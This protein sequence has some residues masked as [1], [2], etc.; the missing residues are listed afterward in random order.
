VSARKV[1]IIGHSLPPSDAYLR[2]FLRS[3]L[4]KNEG[5]TVLVVDPG[6]GLKSYKEFLDGFLSDRVTYE[7]TNFGDAIGKIST[8]LDPV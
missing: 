8:F 4:T 6:E 3:A 5:C 7:H 2:Y 1:V